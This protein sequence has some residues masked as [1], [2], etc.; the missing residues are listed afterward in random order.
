MNGLAQGYAIFTRVAQNSKTTIRSMNSKIEC[1]RDVSR[2]G[3]V[4]WLLFITR[5]LIIWS[6]VS[7]VEN[8]FFQTNLFFV[9]EEHQKKKKFSLCYLIWSIV[10]L[11]A[12]SFLSLRNK[13]A[14]VKM[15]QNDFGL[16]LACCASLKVRSNQQRPSAS[17]EPQAQGSH[18]VLRTMF[19]SNFLVR[20]KKRNPLKCESSMKNSN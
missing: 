18:N 9:F 12:M 11:L 6:S 1:S 10:F 5:A 7:E 20:K 8:L 17:D 19:R 2:G 4:V 14:A 13:N 16:F 3:Q 15:E